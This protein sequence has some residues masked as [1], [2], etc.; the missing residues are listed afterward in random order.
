M[1]TQPMSIKAEAFFAAVNKFSEF[2]LENYEFHCEVCQ[3]TICDLQMKARQFLGDVE[4]SSD[5]NRQSVMFSKAQLD[6]ARELVTKRVCRA[7]ESVVRGAY[8][9]DPNEVITVQCVHSEWKHEPDLDLVA[10]SKL[11]NEDLRIILSREWD[12]DMSKKAKKADLVKEITKR[13]K[14]VQVRCDNTVTGTRSEIG[15]MGTRC[16]D[17]QKKEG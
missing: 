11:Q 17:H 15:A 6:Y 7:Q 5:G 14:N 16:T 3:E 8:R 2:D 4:A 9:I 13:I 10:V 12:V 1:T